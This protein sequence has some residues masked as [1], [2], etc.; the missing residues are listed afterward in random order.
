[1]EK[2][3]SDRK[4]INKKMNTDIHNRIRKKLIED[5]RI[6]E[7]T[8]DSKIVNDIL[9]CDYPSYT[10][11]ISEGRS[12][13]LHELTQYADAI[14]CTT[15]YLLGRTSANNKN[16]I[17]SLRD[18]LRQIMLFDSFDTSDLPF[19]KI[20]ITTETK[21]RGDE[22]MGEDLEFY[23]IPDIRIQD[24]TVSDYRLF[25]RYNELKKAFNLI[26]D[27]DLCINLIDTLLEKYYDNKLYPFK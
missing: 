8:S 25:S 23:E 12:I 14:N 22:F 5:G 19:G 18:L 1:M 17:P 9:K 3:S 2:K 26:E 11:Q 21:T 15:D 13:T 6:D 10:K 7:R 4:E 16:D 27:K 24:D 20:H